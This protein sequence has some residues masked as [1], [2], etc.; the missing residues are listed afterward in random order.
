MIEAQCIAALESA[1]LELPEM[2]DI[3]KPVAQWGEGKP[4]Y[5]RG[6][7]KGKGRSF[8]GPASAI[9]WEC[10]NYPGMFGKGLAGY[11][12]TLPEWAYQLPKAR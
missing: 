11:M 4:I 10:P 9:R 8:F 2:P 1:I 3:S 5:I 12:R 6:L 7:W